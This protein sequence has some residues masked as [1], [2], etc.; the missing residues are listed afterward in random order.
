LTICVW[1][2]FVFLELVGRRH[3]RYED[4]VLD[5]FSAFP[6]FQFEVIEH[7]RFFLG[8]LGL[9]LNSNSSG[10]PGNSD[11][12]DHGEWNGETSRAATFTSNGLLDQ[13]LDPHSSS[14]SFHVECKGLCWAGPCYLLNLCLYFCPI[15]ERE[16]FLSCPEA[17][18]VVG[19]S[20]VY[21]TAILD[22]K[23]T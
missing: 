17:L 21:F 2:S 22:R 10:M 14:D 20:F 16:S 23:Q 6:V 9:D 5:G 7:P 4:D 1:S 19:R 13:K 15:F 12:S 3:G 8:G 18:P 11:G